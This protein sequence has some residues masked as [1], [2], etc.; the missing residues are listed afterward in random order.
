MGFTP[1]QSY[2]LAECFYKFCLALQYPDE[3]KEQINKANIKEDTKR[4]IMETLKGIFAKHNKDVTEKSGAL[5]PFGCLHG[6]GITS[7]SAG[8]SVDAGRSAPNNKG[9]QAILS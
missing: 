9:V 5:A 3:L 8:H 7:D 6:S 4:L 2:D 1:A